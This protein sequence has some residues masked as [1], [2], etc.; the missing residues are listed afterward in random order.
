M[1]A[2][3]TDLFEIYSNPN[4]YRP[5]KEIHQYPY[6]TDSQR[7]KNDLVLIETQEPF[8][9]GP[10]LNIYAACLFDQDSRSFKNVIMAGFGR[11]SA[12]A[13]L[14]ELVEK[15]PQMISANDRSSI[16]LSTRDIP[17]D[18]NDLDMIKVKMQAVSRYLTTANLDQVACNSDWQPK[19]KRLICLG[20]TSACEGKDFPCRPLLHFIEPFLCT[21]DAGAPML[22]L[23]ENQSDARL[24]VAAIVTST[25]NASSVNCGPDQTTRFLLVQPHLKWI[26]SQTKGQLCSRVD[27]SNGSWIHGL[28]FVIRYTSLV[29]LIILALLILVRRR[30]RMQ[31]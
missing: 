31:A 1:G 17:D 30:R 3:S 11:T 10:K 26:R 29:G 21:G 28:A 4:L 25:S 27:K 24:F 8:E 9:L 2:G 5:I 22:T 19:D 18:P 7:G 20:R 15:I 14:D 23:E 6:S 16:D 13:E 12:T